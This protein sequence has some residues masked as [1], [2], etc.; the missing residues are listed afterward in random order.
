MSI[1]WHD[2]VEST[3]DL[4]HALAAAGAE[5]GT[6]VAA[7]I[8]TRG[9]GTRGR[10]WLS[11]AGGLWL[12]VVVRP[13]SV[14]RV[15]LHS[16]RVGLALAD[17]LER[18]S[19]GRLRIRLKWPNDLYL[20]DRKLGGLLAEA[21]WQGDNLGW[22]VVG[23]GLNLTNQLP[24]GSPPV[25]RAVDLGWS[26]AAED[27]APAVVEAVLAGTGRTGELDSAEIDAFERRDWLRG[28]RT[29]RPAAG[30]VL[31]IGASGRLRLQPDQGEPTELL[32]SS[33]LEL[34]N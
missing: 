10:A 12:S 15:E 30:V 5:Q 2:T 1:Q 25:A 22:I 4:A 16:L 11:T 14:E 19:L 8:Q 20:N 13:I 7:R 29:R 3:Q 18:E 21:R 33:D 28:R 23:V 32:D 6:A 26:P 17:R 27:L 24:V 9:R 31:G 34:E